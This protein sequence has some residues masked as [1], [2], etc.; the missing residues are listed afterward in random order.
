MS[1]NSLILFILSLARERKWEERG[2]EAEK[3][4]EGRRERREGKR[5]KENRTQKREGEKRKEK[6]T[7]QFTQLH[8]MYNE[9]ATLNVNS[10]SEAILS[11]YLPIGVYM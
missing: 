10:S 8:W 3:Q 1:P 4:G 2:I 11:R 7:M 9:C 5:E 6:I